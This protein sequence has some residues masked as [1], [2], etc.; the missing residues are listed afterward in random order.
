M[1]MFKQRF[2]LSMEKALKHESVR[3]YRF[4]ASTGCGFIF[5]P[6]T[7]E[8]SSD[9]HK[10]LKGLTYLHKYDRHLERCI[11]LTFIAEEGTGWCDVQWCRLESPWSEDERT[12][13]F[14]KENQPLRELKTAVVE[15]YGLEN[16]PD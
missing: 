13:L 5:I 10:T 11:G 4:V 3:P 14:I 15:R 7:K 2:A 1:K 8:E 16:V 9:K 12:R 6:L